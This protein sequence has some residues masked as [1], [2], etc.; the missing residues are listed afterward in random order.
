MT[1][2]GRTLALR[3]SR[4]HRVHVERVYM[5]D[6]L[7]NVLGL[8]KLQIQAGDTMDKTIS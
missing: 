3:V 5:C 4:P 2:G 1:R 8:D 7:Q 6:S